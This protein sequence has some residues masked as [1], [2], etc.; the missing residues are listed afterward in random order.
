[1]K[2]INI[3]VLILTISCCKDNH[4]LIIENNIISDTIVDSNY[5]IR[6]V[7]LGKKIPDSIKKNQKLINVLYYG[8]DN[9]IHKGQLVCHYSVVNS[10]KLVFDKLLEDKFPIYSVIP[11]NAFEW[12]D[13]KSMLANNTSCFNYRKT[14]SGKLSEHGRGLAIDIKPFDNPYITSNNNIY[15]KGSLY[16]SEAKG[17]ILANSKII[18]YF[19]EIEWKWGG[20]WRYSKDYQHFSL[21]GR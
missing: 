9:K 2:I 12:D 18:K 4:S 6:E 5:T 13:N 14:Q 11:V 16:R 1:M 17:T 3:I 15:P 21:N 19:K 7:F 10:L 8:Y 20:N